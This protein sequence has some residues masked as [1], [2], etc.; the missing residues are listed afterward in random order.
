[1]TEVRFHP[2]ADAEYRAAVAWYRAQSA[3]A[4]R[5]LE[6]EVERILEMI[7]RHPHLYAK[8]DEDYRF[9]VLRKFPYSLIFQFEAPVLLVMAVA[10]SSRSSDYW[11]GRK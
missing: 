11:Q 10:H 5:D 3:T 1:M 7:P 6:N 2:E 9:A 8:Y 4:S